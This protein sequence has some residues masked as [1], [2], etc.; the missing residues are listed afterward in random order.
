MF[1]L[2]RLSDTRKQAEAAGSVNT[3]ED[4]YHSLDVAGPSTAHQGTSFTFK[5]V[6]WGPT[7]MEDRE[8]VGAAEVMHDLLEDSEKI[9]KTKEATVIED[10]Q[11]I[12]DEEEE[13]FILPGV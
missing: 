8:P 1:H 2:F 12:P 11:D 3:Q 7:V 5:H 4:I 10:E 9:E 6:Q 13:E